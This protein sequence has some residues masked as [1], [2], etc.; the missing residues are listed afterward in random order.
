MSQV[1]EVQEVAQ[2]KPDAWKRWWLE[3]QNDRGGRAELRRCATVTE[4]AF[5]APYHLLR[6]MR[7]DPTDH[8]ELARLGLI[9]V[10]LAHVDEDAP[11]TSF[12]K[13]LAEPKGDKAVVSD[14]RFRQLLRTDDL[15]ERL[16]DLVRV[17]RQTNRRAPVEKLAKDLWFWG[18]RAKRQWALDYYANTTSSN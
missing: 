18:E 10:V 15:D 8:W 13:L 14:A 6:R 12:A 2:T 1:A 4:A 11:G 9:A 5:C 7:G 3:L 16:G 17:V